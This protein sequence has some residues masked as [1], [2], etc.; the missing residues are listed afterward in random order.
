M[1]TQL[2]DITFIFWDEIDNKNM[3]CI[4]MACGYQR[5]RW[6]GY[7]FEI[8][9]TVKLHDFR[10]SRKAKIPLCSECPE[11]CLQ[12]CDMSK[13]GVWLLN[14]DE[15][16]LDALDDHRDEEVEKWE[17]ENPD[18][19]VKKL[20]QQDLPPGMRRFPKFKARKGCGLWLLSLLVAVYLTLAVG[21]IFS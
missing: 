19:N 15:E 5:A 8:D 18:V 9:L 1:S 4:C 13:K 2:P 10:A 6:R 12:A 21:W 17:Q 3:P 20:K 16:F 14:V 7:T 11:K